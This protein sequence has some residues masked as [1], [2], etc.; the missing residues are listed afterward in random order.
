MKAQLSEVRSIRTGKLQTEKKKL[1]KCLMHAYQSIPLLYKI[2]VFLLLTLYIIYIYRKLVTIIF[3]HLQKR[4]QEVITYTLEAIRHGKM[5]YDIMDDTLTH[6]EAAECSRSSR[7]V[8]RKS[9]FLWK[10]VDSSVVLN[11]L[12]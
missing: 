8:M 2:F 5:T 11:V 3:T 7:K 9:E 6:F 4:I 10:S 1:K 12:V